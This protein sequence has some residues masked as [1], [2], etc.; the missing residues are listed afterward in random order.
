MATFAAAT[1]PTSTIPT[2]A[3]AQRRVDHFVAITCS[4]PNDS[5]DLYSDDCRSHAQLVSPSRDPIGFEAGSTCLYEYCHSNPV[6]SIDPS[7]LKC[8]PHVQKPTNWADWEGNS[9]LFWRRIYGWAWHYEYTYVFALNKTFTDA[10]F[11]IAAASTINLGYPH[12][13]LGAR[14]IGKGKAISRVKCKISFTDDCKAS[15]DY[16]TV[17][18]TPKNQKHNQY[19]YWFSLANYKYEYNGSVVTFAYRI[20]GGFDFKG[21]KFDPGIEYTLGA[22][23][24]TGGFDGQNSD[25]DNFPD[26]GD[27]SYQCECDK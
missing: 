4:D 1:K 21:P 24:L 7:G 15:V 14:E 22:I 12:G 23:T 9:M 11:Y 20:E 2:C 3:P 10:T 5:C 19:Q 13:P 25:L 26:E 18:V 8:S 27:V 16:C 17:V 6:R